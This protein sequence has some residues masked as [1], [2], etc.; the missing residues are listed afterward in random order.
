M[1]PI[2]TVT[3]PAKVNLYLE[4]GGVRP[5]GYHD[6]VT[7]LQTLALHDTLT[8]A[9][10]DGLEVVCTPDLGMPAEENLV[11]RAA[12]ALAHGVARPPHVR[13]EVD[14]AIP[15]GAGLGGG[16][17]DAAAALVGLAALWGIA[18]DAP[19]LA[20]V[21]AA[22]GADVPFFFTGGTA[23]FTGRGDVR[24]ARYP[25]PELDITLVKPAPSLPTAAAYVAFDLL[26]PPP[27]GDPEAM[28]AACESND[29]RR[30]AAALHNNFTDVS[31]GLVSEIADALAWSAAAEG[32]LGVAMAGSG[33]ATFAVCA[34][35][36]GA[37]T[38]ADAARR[39]GW[40]AV[41]TRTTGSGAR[42]HH[43]P[44]EQ[45]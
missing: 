15:S 18:A 30:V 39:Q 11:H 9:P 44:R 22:L 38:V 36:G 10:S 5:D 19:V 17:S 2:L 13:I 4:V 42:V 43:M 24:V 23:L 45:L 26:G 16:S 8:F 12:L 3:A 6:V 14:K 33:S 1:P 31:A 34:D 32:V 35:A 28:R 7:V 40:W 21:A 37:E 29:P 25:T 41:A 20:R 27:A